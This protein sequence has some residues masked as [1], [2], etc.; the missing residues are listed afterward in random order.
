MTYYFFTDP[1]D[2][3]P[4]GGGLGNTIDASVSGYVEDI[5]RFHDEVYRYVFELVD[6]LILYLPKVLKMIDLELDNWILFEMVITK[7]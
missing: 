4:A 7:G 2:V 5:H 6:E 1:Y 3:C